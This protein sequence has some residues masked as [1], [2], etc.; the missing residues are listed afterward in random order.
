VYLHCVVDEEERDVNPLDRYPEIRKILYDVQWLT[1]LGLGLAG[2]VL[3]ILGQS[4]LWFI[5]AGAIA[6]F[7]W[8]Y[9]GITASTNVTQ[10]TPV[11]HYDDDHDDEVGEG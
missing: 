10:P 7:L 2:V 3:T 9:T 8:T 6:N 11:E 4:P 5:L 1:N